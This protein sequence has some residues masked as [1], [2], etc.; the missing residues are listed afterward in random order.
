MQPF[1]IEREFAGVSRRRLWQAWSEAGQLQRWWGPKG[2]RIAVEQFDFRPGG[3]FHYAMHFGGAPPMWGRFLYREI[4]APDRIVWLN[5]F[6]NA[7]C[8]IARA[9]FSEACPLE[10][11]NVVTFSERAGAARVVLQAGPFGAED[12][13]LAYFDELR[14]SLEQGYGGTFEQLA[15]HLRALG[16]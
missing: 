1:V 8:G 13:E 12:D 16:A 10:I 14:P 4:A 7:R 9:P 11:E 5:S 6:A 15:A 2:C 3:F